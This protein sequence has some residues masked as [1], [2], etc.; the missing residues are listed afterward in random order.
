[1]AEVNEK[2]YF[3]KLL[4]SANNKLF[5]RKDIDYKEFEK[6]YGNVNLDS[7]RQEINDFKAR[8]RVGLDVSVSD[9]DDIFIENSAIAIIAFVVCAV[10]YILVANHFSAPEDIS[11]LLYIGAILAGSTATGLYNIGK[12]NQQTALK[13]PDM[14]L[15]KVDLIANEGIL[16]IAEIEESVKALRDKEG[17]TKDIMQRY[18]YSKQLK[19]AQKTDKAIKKNAKQYGSIKNEDCSQLSRDNTIDKADFF[20]HL[21]NNPI[22]TTKSKTT[23]IKAATK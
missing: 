13:K 22:K 19:T 3:E 17:I 15:A 23:K 11:T 12:Q 14:R 21:A 1:M 4:E 6:R 5:V 18:Y 20:D 16:R 7:L 10:P 8:T 9:S 2:G